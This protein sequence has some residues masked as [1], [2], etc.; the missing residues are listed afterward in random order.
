MPTSHRYFR[1]V[2]ISSS[3]SLSVLLSASEWVLGVAWISAPRTLIASSAA[4]NF[5]ACVLLAVT[6]WVLG[7]RASSSTCK[8]SKNRRKRSSGSNIKSYRHKPGRACSCAPVHC[9]PCGKKR[10]EGSSTASASA[11]LPTR[12]NRLSVFSRAPAH[13]PHGV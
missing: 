3:S 2:R 1:R 11:L 6:P 12:H 7:P 4:A 13:T 10:L 8:R 5:S 9:T